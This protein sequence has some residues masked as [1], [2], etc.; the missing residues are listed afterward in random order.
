MPPED[1]QAF[2]SDNW[3]E[4]FKGMTLRDYFAARALVGIMTNH[5]QMENMQKAYDEDSED[6][7]YMDYGPYKISQK[8][9]QIADAMLKEREKQS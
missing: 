6:M 8:A 7:I 9:Y 4:H 1:I 2:P 5:I 3:I